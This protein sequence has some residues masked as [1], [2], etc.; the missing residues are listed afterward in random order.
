MINEFECSLYDMYIA[1][2]LDCKNNEKNHM[3][4]WY[5]LLLYNFVISVYDFIDW[6]NTEVIYVNKYLL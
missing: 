2:C 5:K 4:Y 6:R 1:Y 3:D